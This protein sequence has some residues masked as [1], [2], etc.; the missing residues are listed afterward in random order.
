MRDAMNLTLNQLGCIHARTLELLETAGVDFR[1][2]KASDFLKKKGFRTDGTRVFITEAQLM[3]AVDG[4]P[5]RFT[6][7]SPTSDRRVDIGWDDFV[8]TSTAGANAIMDLDGNRRDA[9]FTDY[10]SFLKLNHT[11]DVLQAASPLMVQPND[12]P[13]K[14]A[15]IRLMIA[16]LT[17]SDKP[18]MSL[19][20][21]PAAVADSFRLLA[22]CV[23]S[24]K[25]LEARHHTVFLVSVLSPLGFAPH[26]SDALM[27]V[28]RAN[29]P[30]IVANMAMAGSTAPIR[31]EDA[32][33]LGNAEILGGLVLAQAVRPGVPVVYGSTSCSMDM[34][35]MTAGLGSPETLRIH[36]CAIQ[37]ARFY[38]LP[39]RT[40]GSLTDAHLPDGRAMAESALT[41]ENAL[42]HGA[43]I[44]MHGCGMVSSYLGTCFEKW[45]MDEENC[46]VLTHSLAPLDFE[47]SHMERLL[48]PGGTAGYLTHPDTFRLCRSQYR[49]ELK[50]MAPHGKWLAAGSRSFREEVSDCLARRLAEYQRPEFGPALEKELN[51]LMGATA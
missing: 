15:H 45:L 5:E 11:S 1:S 33:I 28:A 37:L 24:Q 41:L 8:I 23:G 50:A 25:A 44:I 31:V 4:A 51:R 30:M 2:P 26:Q 47:S 10:I 42:C 32:V 40:G 3:D 20:D 39:C 46:R 12:I 48:P 38:G 7:H 18:C 9:L 22:G 16:T 35:T 29:Q 19:G 14:T 27:A 6:L 21:G 13:A 43:H 36:R 34:K 17:H 49:S